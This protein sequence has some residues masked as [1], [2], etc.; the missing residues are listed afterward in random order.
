MYKLSSYIELSSEKNKNQELEYFAVISAKR[1]KVFLI[2]ET[3]FHFLNHFEMPNSL[4]KVFGYYKAEFKL[5]NNEEETLLKDQL[6]TFFNDLTK[7]KWII[8]DGKVEKLVEFE[9]LFQDKD[10]FLNYKVLSVLGNNKIT[11][12]YLVRDLN[13]NRKRVIKLLNKLKF[14]DE[15]SFDK[16]S[17]HFKEE[18]NF[19]NKFNSIYINK[20]LG[21]K[22]YNRQPYILLK[23]ID[24]IS[25]SKFVKANKLKTSEKLKLILKM[26][27]GFSIIHQ[28]NVYHGDIHFSNILVKKNGVPVIIDFGYSNK[29]EFN[30]EINKGKVRNG[31][32]YAFIPPERALR[33][34]DRR[35]SKVTHFQSEVYQIGLIIYYVFTKDLPFKADTWK[36][37]VD[38]KQ[39][40]NL[41]EN[42]AFLKRRMPVQVKQFIIKCLESNPE[43]RF[44][45]ASSMYANW[46]VIYKKYV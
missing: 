12:V 45:N 13:T 18:Y 2:N 42:K 33:S 39:Q 31:G 29:V 9:T 8:P 44:S 19:A 36:T 3:I 34:I 32:V 6:Q 7:R 15:K 16:Y 21:F 17:F 24:G 25:I 30:N 37:M 10:T 22:T 38:E 5:K 20:T 46:K 35:F 28:N 27:K 26:L 41:S 11:D 1:T 4:D 23:Q 14:K 43:N 40:L